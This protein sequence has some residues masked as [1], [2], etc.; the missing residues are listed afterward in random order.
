MVWGHCSVTYSNRLLKLQKRAARIVLRADIMTLSE[1]MFRE[2]NWLPFYKRVQYHTYILMYKTLN[3]LAPEHL[4]ERFI[5]I[6]ETHDRNP[7][8]TDSGL[9]KVPYS[10]TWYYDNSFTVTGAKMW[11]SLPL[12]IRQSPSLGSFKGRIKSHLLGINCGVGQ[13]VPN[14]RFPPCPHFPPP[15]PRFPPPRPPLPSP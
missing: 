9:L 4:S 1:T 2:L 13:G 12:N 14:P 15:R 5:K 10:R 7:R 3:N 11:N 6:S 8:S